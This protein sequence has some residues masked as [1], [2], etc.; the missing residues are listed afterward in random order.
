LRV[1][2]Q[3]FDHNVMDITKLKAA[4]QEEANRLTVQRNLHQ[5]IYDLKKRVK[6]H[7]QSSSNITVIAFGF[8]QNLPVPDM[9]TN[10][11]FYSRQA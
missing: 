7:C 11:V 5:A 6:L 8:K 1:A 4:T 10:T 3:T 2:E 9:T